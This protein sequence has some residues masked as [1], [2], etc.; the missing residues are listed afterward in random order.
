MPVDAITKSLFAR[1]QIQEPV[2]VPYLSPM[3]IPSSTTI[4]IPDTRKT[5]LASGLPITDR[6]KKDANADP[7][8]VKRIIMESKK[9]GVDP[10]TA[11]AI[12]HQETNFK[13]RNDDHDAFHVLDPSNDDPSDDP[14]HLG[15]RAVK[16]KLAYGKSLGKK[17]EASVLQAYN[18]YGKIGLS[19]EDRSKK[20]YGIDVSK[21]QIDM[22]KNPVYG[23]RIIDIRDNILKKNPNIVKLVNSI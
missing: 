16:D 3:S 13:V 20:Y 14:I 11:L 23:K 17:D 15:V 1:S 9:Q 10:Y 6:N 12:A 21:Q 18:G 7:D 5:D 8:V 2:V 19:S 4:K 22:N